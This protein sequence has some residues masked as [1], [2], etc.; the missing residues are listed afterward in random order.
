MQ[1]FYLYEKLSTRQQL[2]TKGRE[3]TT[4]AR[5]KAF[6]LPFTHVDP[7]KCGFA[8]LEFPGWLKTFDEYSVDTDKILSNMHEFM[9]QNEKMRFLWCEFVFFERWWRK[10]S[11][12]V[13]EEVRA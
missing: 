4:H 7:G 11:E 8:V 9:T 6:V 13:K 5:I 2:G 12:K 3:K 1:T 10:Q